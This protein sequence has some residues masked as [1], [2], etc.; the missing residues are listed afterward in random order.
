MTRKKKIIHHPTG[1]MFEY[2]GRFYRTVRIEPGETEVCKLC[3][4]GKPKSN[5][6]YRAHGCKDHVCELDGDGVFYEEVK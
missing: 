6:D 4:F 3:A 1:E 5:D 2:A